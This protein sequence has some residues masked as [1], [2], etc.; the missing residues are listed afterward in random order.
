VTAA[1]LDLR[2]AN[3]ATPR[4]RG[5]L[6]WLI[7]VFVVPVLFACAMVG[8]LAS[9]LTT[10][11]TLLVIVAVYLPV[12]AWAARSA[13]HPRLSRVVWVAFCVK[14]VG[15]C[16][17]YLMITVVYGTGDAKSYHSAGAVLA[18]SYRKGNFGVP[19][20]GYRAEGTMA[21]RV[22]VGLIYSVTGSDILVGA[23]VFSLLSFTGVILL[24]KAF[25]IGVPDGDH[26]RYG[27]L[28]LLLPSMWFWPSS[29]G[30]EAWMLFS[31]GVLAY[32]AARVYSRLPG[33]F[34]LLAAG[35]AACAI[36]RPHVALV[37]FC[38]SSAAL[39]LR[40]SSERR[41]FN[42]LGK[43]LILLPMV[44]GGVLLVSKSQSFLKLDQ[45]SVSGI[46]AAG[47]LAEKNSNQGGSSFTPTPVQNVGQLPMAFVTVLF[48]PFPTEARSA[49]PLVIS[50]EGTFLLL[51]T[52]RS[53]RRVLRGLRAVRRTP[54]LGL[55]TLAT[56]MFVVIFA[57]FANFGILARERVQVFPFALAFL[58]A[59]PSRRALGPG[60]GS[61]SQEP[62][63][64][65]LQK[66]ARRQ[67]RDVAS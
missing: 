5:G 11:P 2:A 44:F 45:F 20:P 9:V 14:L 29:L 39:L 57:N 59:V 49:L 28:L 35:T 21:I 26:L 31:L 34:L 19:I 53:W 63:Q 13:P 18:R 30:K 54:Y 41:R 25:G 37:A 17:R 56:L 16:L 52:A 42:R 6:R 62:V 61:E 10:I 12:V 46:Q 23:L 43:L 51:L 22:I 40:S 67:G 50:V 1:S 4:G 58:A 60:P 55:C 32:G 24:V 38:A 65:R 8:G 66:A 3:R 64:R 27:R 7:P 47:E 33:G 48:R 15:Y 36:V